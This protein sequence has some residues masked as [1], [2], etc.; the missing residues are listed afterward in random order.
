MT[1][2]RGDQ[3]PPASTEETQGGAECKLGT[4]LRFSKPSIHH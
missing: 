4:A 2:D 1:P 3:G